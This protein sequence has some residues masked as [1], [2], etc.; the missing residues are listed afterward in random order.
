MQSMS[1]SKRYDSGMRIQLSSLAE[2]GTTREQ[3][4]A[5]ARRMAAEALSRHGEAIRAVGI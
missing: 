3:K 4:L 2:A 1:E 5:M